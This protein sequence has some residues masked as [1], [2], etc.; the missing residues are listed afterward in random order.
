MTAPAPARRNPSSD[1]IVAAASVVNQQS[2]RAGCHD[3]RR[4][5]ASSTRRVRSACDLA[6]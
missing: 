6:R 5:T 2:T 1:G 4:P 3:V